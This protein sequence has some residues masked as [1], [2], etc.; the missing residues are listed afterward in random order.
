MTTLS[1]K[2]DVCVLAVAGEL[3]K[4]TVGQF[5]QLVDECLLDD[6]R[7]FVVECTECTGID[8]QGLEALTRLNRSCQEKLGMSKIASPGDWL[9]K[10][11][12]ITRL[13]EELETCQT[14]DEALTALK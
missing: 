14:L 10:V 5:Q 7:D 9:T 8:S 4:A 13:N 3:N 11:F 6:A 2:N 12:E 1:R